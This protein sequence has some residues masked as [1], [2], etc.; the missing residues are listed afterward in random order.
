MNPNLQDWRSTAGFRTLENSIVAV[1]W[2][3]AAGYSRRSLPSKEMLTV[4]LLLLSQ[5]GGSWRKL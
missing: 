3:M 2:K 4:G 1:R 5:A